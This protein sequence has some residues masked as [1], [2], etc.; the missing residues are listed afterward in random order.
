MGWPL[1][2]SWYTVPNCF[3][4]SWFTW[5]PPGLRRNIGFKKSC[6]PHF[7]EG[8]GQLTV[9]TSSSVPC[10]LTVILSHSWRLRAVERMGVMDTVAHR[11][12][13]SRISLMFQR[14]LWPQPCASCVGWGRPSHQ[15]CHFHL[16]Q[17]F[18]ASLCPWL[19]LWEQDDHCSP[20][21][22]FWRVSFTDALSSF[23]NQL[24]WWCCH[25][26]FRRWT[27]GQSSGP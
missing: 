14:D 23:H 21:C 10:Y 17:C 20:D 18:P 26:L 4:E 24:P 2:V 15:Y 5:L 12:A 3:L 19:V 9:E 8:G 1:K 27:W 13:A 16:S 7:R 22:P 25:R 11:W 6:W